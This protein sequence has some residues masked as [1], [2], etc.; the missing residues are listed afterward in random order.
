MQQDWKSP[1]KKLMEEYV[2]QC[3]QSFIE[4]KEYAVAWHYRNMP[5]TALDAAKELY[6]KLLAC[7]AQGPVN[8]LDGHKVIEVRLKEANKGAAIERVL[9]HAAYDFILCVGDDITDEDMFERLADRAE[10]FT[11]KIG[12]G[13]TAARYSL[14]T[15]YMVQSLLT[16]LGA[17]P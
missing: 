14:H 8:V 15:P 11:I 10:A 12:N 1:V 7:T 2:P 9:G 16:E 4:E 5:A 3:P 13:A 6:R 17:H